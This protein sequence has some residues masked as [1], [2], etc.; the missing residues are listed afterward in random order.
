MVA[1]RSPDVLFPAVTW[2]YVAAAE[3]VPGSGRSPA[4][5]LRVRLTPAV[6][7]FWRLSVPNTCQS[8]SP[9]RASHASIGPARLSQGSPYRGRVF[10]AD[11]LDPELR[12]CVLGLGAVDR[13]G[14]GGDYFWGSL[15][16]VAGCS[17]LS[18]PAAVSDALRRADELARTD[19]LRPVR[20]SYHPPADR[21]GTRQKRAFWQEY[22]NA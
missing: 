7:G 15:P 16:P 5:Q 14:Y 19:P 6:D 22:G 2:T 20:R 4:L 11:L 1:H 12:R 13:A 8:L 21:R 17:E 3:T 18:E 9:G 10:L